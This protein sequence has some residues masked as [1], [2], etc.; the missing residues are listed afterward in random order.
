MVE[1]KPLWVGDMGGQGVAYMVL[2][3]V[4]YPSMGGGL[5][6]TSTELSS[7]LSGI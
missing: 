4:P 7:A 5:P 6:L 2:S 3:I 1:D